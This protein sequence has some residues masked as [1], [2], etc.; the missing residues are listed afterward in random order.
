MRILVTGTFDDLHPGHIF[1]LEEAMKRVVETSEAHVSAGE[2][3]VIVARDS[4][5]M[6]I[7]GHAPLQNEDTR[8]TAIEKLFLDA[9]VVLGDPENFLKPVLAIKPDLILLGYD[10][11][12]PPDV[13]EEDLGCEIERL[14][15]FQPHIHKSSLRRKNQ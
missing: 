5:V 2:L 14:P 7:K 13:K 9:H 3:F 10:Q 6:R 4:N 15:A 12:L 8:K 1:V 11:K